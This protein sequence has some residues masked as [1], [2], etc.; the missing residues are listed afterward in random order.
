MD[1]E[2]QENLSIDSGYPG[3]VDSYY[4]WANHQDDYGAPGSVN[5]DYGETP[6]DISSPM[7]Q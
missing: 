2:V 5:S 6:S 3:T 1:S 4:G 7:S